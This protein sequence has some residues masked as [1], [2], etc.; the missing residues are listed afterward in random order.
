ME[1]KVHNNSPQR[2]NRNTVRLQEYDYRTAGGYFITICTHERACTLGN[3]ANGIVRLSQ[4]GETVEEEWLKTMT[5]RPYVVLDEYV[6][7]PNHL[8]GILVID[9]GAEVQQVMQG[10]VFNQD[11]AAPCPY[12]GSRMKLARKDL[13]GRPAD[14]YI[15]SCA[16]SRQ[17][18]QGGSGIWSRM[19]G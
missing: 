9:G 11:T 12:E 10:Q 17:P 14:H 8:H 15:R 6:I 5:I 4:W 7:M 16:H 3:I 2:K 1:P 19:M 13:A 18:S